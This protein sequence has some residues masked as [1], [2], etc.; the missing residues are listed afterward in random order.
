VA[1]LVVLL[2]GEEFTD[3]TEAVSRM[4]LQLSIRRFSHDRKRLPNVVIVPIAARENTRRIVRAGSRQLSLWGARVEHVM[5]ADSDTA[6][7]AVH[8]AALERADLIC[9]PDGSPLDAVQALQNTQALTLMG[10]AWASGALLM[11]SGASAMALCAQYWDGGV[12]EHGLD[13][14]HNLAVLPHHE[15]IAARFSAERLRRDLPPET[16]IIGL[17]DATAIIIDVPTPPSSASQMQP[18]DLA[19]PADA[20]SLP[21]RVMGAGEVTV[22]RADSQ[23]VY[24]DGQTFSLDPS[25]TG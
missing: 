23:D 14:L 11:A 12:W 15:T 6:D 18:A 25:V 20:A 13:L 4:M 16:I 8:I 7:G 3:A 2:G 17:D 24:T 19:T 5:S 10:R 21:V 9:L 1:K 22:Y